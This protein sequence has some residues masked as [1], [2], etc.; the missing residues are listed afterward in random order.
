LRDEWSWDNSFPAVPEL[1]DQIQSHLQQDLRHPLIIVSA[2]IIAAA[3]T[4]YFPDDARH[5]GSRDEQETNKSSP[6]SPEQVR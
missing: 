2:I 4:H 1:S 6:K 3:V 5:N